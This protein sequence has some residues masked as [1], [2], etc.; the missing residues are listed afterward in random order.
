MALQT[1]GS[2]GWARQ[3]KKGG[4]KKRATGFK[5]FLLGLR[6]VSA[7][8]SRLVFLLRKN[9]L[10]NLSVLFVFAFFFFNNSLYWD[11]ASSISASVKEQPVTS[12]VT[13]QSPRLELEPARR[14]ADSRSPSP[15]I[16]FWERTV[17][18]GSSEEGLDRWH[19]QFSV[20]PCHP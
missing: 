8:G 9:L 4:D 18:A 14:P 6:P 7:L 16:S 11:L 20:M 1:S 13:H 12:T 2:L 15:V 19:A 10:R 5:I 3:D 17:Q